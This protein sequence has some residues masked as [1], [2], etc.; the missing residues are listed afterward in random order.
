ME[1]LVNVQK[2]PKS[3]SKIET[4]DLNFPRCR[5]FCI[6]FQRIDKS[7]VTFDTN[8]LFSL[9]PNEINLFWRPF[10]IQF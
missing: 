2:I 7:M 5:I 8:R 1:L 4:L 10:H 6:S 3:M 9:K